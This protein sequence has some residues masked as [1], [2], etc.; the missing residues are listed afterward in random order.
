MKKG[1]ALSLVWRRANGHV[2]VTPSCWARVLGK[3]AGMN[4][5][6]DT[7]VPVRAADIFFFIVFSRSDETRGLVLTGSMTIG[8]G[9]VNPTK[10]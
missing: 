3:G 8:G 7:N 1:A 6:A 2:L 4:H 5:T 9:A 10:L